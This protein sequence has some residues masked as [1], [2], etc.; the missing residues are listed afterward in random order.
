MLAAHQDWNIDAFDFNSAYL[1]GELG[2]DKEIYM[3]EPP[4]YETSGEDS[5]K[6]LQKAIYRLKQAGQ[7]WYD[8]LTHVLT[9][10]GFRVSSADPGVFVACKG[11]HILILAAHVDDCIITRSSPRL[12]QD[13]KQKLND[14]YALTDLRP[15]NWLLGIKVTR[16][17]EAQTILLSQKGYI[18]SILAQF[19]LQDAKAVNTPMLPSATYSKEDCPA[20]DT[21]HACM[22]R[23]PYHEAIG[24]LMYASVATHP[25]ITFAVSTLSQFLDNPGEAH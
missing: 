21:K 18:S 5:I 7:K 22:A 8:A 2:E 24:S 16:D 15:V 19:N 25:D 13:F 23:V 14:C 4:G 20:N 11:E 17:Q 1:N 3:E 12:I 10:I 9:D 6:R